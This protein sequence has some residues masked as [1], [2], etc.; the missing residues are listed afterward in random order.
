[1]VRVQPSYKHTSEVKIV[2]IVYK[3]LDKIR[4]MPTK[5]M[6]PL[7]YLNAQHVYVN[8]KILKR[9]R[10]G[11]L[12]SNLILIAIG[13]V[14]YLMLSGVDAFAILEQ[15]GRMNAPSANSGFGPTANPTSTEIALVPTQAQEFNDLSLKFNEPK[16][17]FLMTKDEALKLI[18]ETYP[19]QLEITANERIMQ[20]RSTMPVI[21]VLIQ[22]I[23]E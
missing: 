15:L 19:G 2:P 9:L 8:E 11:D 12:S 16:P 7:I 4:L 14:V 5:E 13:A 6:I 20:K 17:N 21:L 22:R 23:M 10:A 3:R 1:M 18:K